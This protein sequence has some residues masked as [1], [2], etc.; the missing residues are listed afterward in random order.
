M[1]PNPWRGLRGLPADVWLLFATTLVNRTGTMA[2][3]FL[4]LYLTQHMHLP[5][6][7]AGAAL[8]VYGV[9]SLCSAP[10]AGWLCDRLGALRVM[11]MSLIL[12]GLLLLLFPLAHTFP[13]V[14]ALTF[15]WALAG[16][17]TRPAS[18]AAL[19]DAA[20]PEQRR[21][22][23]S[24]NRLAVNLGMSIGPA[25]GGLLATVSFP[26]L[27]L[28]DG[29]TS[30]AAGIVLAIASRRM[31]A[32]RAAGGAPAVE[33]EAGPRSGPG[34]LADRPFLLFLAGAF[35]VGVIFFQHTAAMPLFLVRELGLSSALF[36]MLFVVNTVLI[37]LLEVPLNLSMAQWSHRR[38]LV[39]GCLLCGA[40]FGAM[41]LVSEPWH[42]LLTTVVWT[43]GE[44]ILFPGSAAFVADAAPAS[45]RG[46]YMG[47]YT[48]A[49]GLAFAVGPWAG[50]IVLDWA[51]G[52]L[53]WSLMLLL[54]AAAAIVM[55]IAA[56]HADPALLLSKEFAPATPS[57]SAE[58]V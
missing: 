1:I 58:A 24:L 5:A 29:G 4:V 13:A 16:E 52:T 7:V 40:G 32:L 17:A 41:A 9:G 23:V 22:A 44:M 50:T 55:G 36:G 10:F 56:R 14:L 6:R 21:A 26:A 35:L 12:S 20:V 8:T 11:E 30:L 54:G 42:L 31:V 46:A 19:A 34:V 43:F 39:L 57:G 38:T 53:L 25:A 49:F 28:V 18:L 47:A 2:L 45:R 33:R 51:G 27:F 3:P 37:V 15:A 48:M